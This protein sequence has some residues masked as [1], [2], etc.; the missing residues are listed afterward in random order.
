MLLEQRQ[1]NSITNKYIERS[2]SLEH[3]QLL[4]S[5]HFGSWLGLNASNRTP[6]KSFLKLSDTCVFELKF[7]QSHYMMHV[8]KYNARSML[9]MA[10]PAKCPGYSYRSSPR[11]VHNYIRRVLSGK[12]PCKSQ[13]FCCFV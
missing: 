6:N 2:W 4:S 9:H 12:V 5:R 1:E 11:V 7:S 10:E 3:E 8:L 13:M